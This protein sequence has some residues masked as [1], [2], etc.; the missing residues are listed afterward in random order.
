MPYQGESIPP[1]RWRRL[2]VAAA[3]ALSLFDACLM[4]YIFLFGKVAVRLGGSAIGIGKVKLTC[5]KLSPPFL[6]LL[7]ILLFSAAVR[8][9]DPLGRLGRW[10]TARRTPL[11]RA[12]VVLALAAA[13]RFWNLAGHSLSPDELLWSACGRGMIFNVRVREFKK[14]TAD[15]GHPG[16]VPAAMIGAS[17]AY[18]GKGT[19]PFSREL[20][21]PIVAWRLPVAAAGA[22]TCLIL[23]L[24]GRL[25]LGDRAAFWA[26]VFLALNPGHIASSRVAMLDAT[27]ALFFLLTLL[28]YAVGEERG[29]PRWKLSSGVFFGLALLTK[30]PASLLPALV[31]AWK[32]GARLAYPGRKA[33]FWD[34]ADLA[35]LGIG[36]A[37]YFTL[38]TRLWSDPSELPWGRFARAAPAVGA[39][40]GAIGAIGSLPWLPIAAG[41]SCAAAVALLARGR[42]A[43]SVSRHALA[44][45]AVLLFVRIFRRPMANEA[46]HYA[47]ISR[48]ADA[49]H[50][51][52][53][54]GRVVVAPPRWFYAF[55]LC[56]RTPPVM[57]PLLAVGITRSCA[58][59]LR[60]RDGAAPLMLCLLTP[61]FFIAAM[62]GSA[63]M[64]FRYIEPAIPFLCAVSAVGF[65]SLLDAAG[66]CAA[67][68]FLRG[69]AGALARAA[70]VACLLV[71]IAGTAPAYDLYFNS[72]I[73]GL[74]GAARRISV[75]FGV[76]SRE[77][78]EYL[79]RHLRKGDTV[80]ALGIAG[81]MDYYLKRMMPAG[82]AGVRVNAAPRPD[83]DWL[84]VPLS[85]RLRFPQADRIL[86]DYPFRLV[87]S[88]R[89]RGVDFVDV[90]RLGKKPG[91][92]RRPGV[93]CAM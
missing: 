39:A 19:S 29:N 13:P 68:P 24:L 35:W 25:I 41:V 36:L 55:M 64:G 30:T 20:L 37:L 5:S 71:P 51:K 9:P 42:R 28:C 48:F 49:G 83:A 50:M 87:H 34:K 58:D 88:V 75:G 56:I 10:I 43:R 72:F 18:L 53:W 84:V 16:I 66:R 14:A 65:T 21:D 12:A 7:A 54:M 2:A 38:F 11:L 93:D 67:S 23:Y 52:Y 33:R 79:S 1:A 90:Y 45:L 85:H 89:W 6:A 76:G 73:G 63:K 62:S 17:D 60:R 3:A 57:L 61:F 40:I 82:G 92:G 32:I 4:L 26:A 46:L 15:L 59:L 91:E 22:A 81:E 8:R 27:L 31:A 70:V 77:A 44:A 80:C 78:A 69:A 47:A 74:P 86:R